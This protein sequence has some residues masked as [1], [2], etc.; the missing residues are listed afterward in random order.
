MRRA[1]F[2]WKPGSSRARTERRSTRRTPH[3][4]WGIVEPVDRQ[5]EWSLRALE[6]AEQTGDART[7]SWLG[8]LYNN[9]GWSYHELGRYEEALTF[10][11]KSLE[12]RREEGQP[13]RIRIAAWSV[14]KVLRSLGRYGEALAMQRETSEAAEAAGEPDGYIEEEIGGCL[15]AMERDQEARPHFARAHEMLSGDGSLVENEP[16]RLERLRALGL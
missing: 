2:F 3:T 16:E 8:P 15:L 5:L 11:E 1:R 9:I 12:Y 7:R 4:C 10:F 13:R 14:G 6:I